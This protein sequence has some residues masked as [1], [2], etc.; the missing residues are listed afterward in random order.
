MKCSQPVYPVVSAIAEM[1]VVLRFPIWLVLPNHGGQLLQ[2][3][4]GI[5]QGSALRS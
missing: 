1:L 5:S 2:S 4:V 3:T